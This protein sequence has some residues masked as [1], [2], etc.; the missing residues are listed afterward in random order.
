MPDL[1]T[2]TILE[3]AIFYDVSSETVRRRTRDGTLPHTRD[4]RGKIFLRREDL[5]QVFLPKLAR[6]EIAGVMRFLKIQI[7]KENVHG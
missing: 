2:L 4:R 1:T 3:A 5:D 6:R 7:R